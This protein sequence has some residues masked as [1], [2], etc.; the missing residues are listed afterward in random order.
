MGATSVS[1]M[2]LDG[3]LEIEVILN[4]T[5][6]GGVIMGASCDIIEHVYISIIVGLLAGSV[7]AIAF[8][9]ITPYLKEKINLSDTCGV[10][11][12]HGIPSIMGCIVSAIACLFLNA[13]NVRNSAEFRA[14]MFPLFKDK[15][16]LY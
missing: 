16:A 8:I 13:E 3:K 7:S 10:N 2:L 9:K 14:G 12:L 5:L 11:N 6:A 4:A 15:T 1:R